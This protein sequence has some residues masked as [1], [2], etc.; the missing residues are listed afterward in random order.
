MSSDAQSVS[1]ID[2]YR[3]N[4]DAVHVVRFPASVDPTVS[5]WNIGAQV[6]MEVDWHRRM[7][8][9]SCAY[10]RHFS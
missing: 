2:A 9:K 6:H 4:L 10:N 1:V 3:H 7:Y 8:R 5:G